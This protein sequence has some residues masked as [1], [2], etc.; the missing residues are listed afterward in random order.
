MDMDFSQSPQQDCKLG[1]DTIVPALPMR[2]LNLPPGKVVRPQSAEKRR[3]LA[4]VSLLKADSKESIHTHPDVPDAKSAKLAADDQ[5]MVDVVEKGKQPYFT[6][7]YLGWMGMEPLG[8]KCD[9]GKL[10]CP[11]CARAIGTW[12]WKPDSSSCEVGT[13][14]IPLFRALRSSVQL[15][16]LPL[17]ATPMSTPRLADPSPRDSMGED[18]SNMDTAEN[19]AGGASNLLHK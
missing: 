6:V 3:W 4:R 9:E 1:R 15:A 5:G 2:S 17:D 8:T 18:G 10:E 13:P 12:S 14:L 7:E 19:A 11:G 16:D